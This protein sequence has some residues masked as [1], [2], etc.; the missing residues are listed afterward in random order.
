MAIEFKDVLD[1]T[2]VD[3]NT[4]N[5]VKRQG[6]L[7]ISD[8]DGLQAELDS[9]AADSDLTS[10]TGDISNP[11][12]VTKDQ[13]GLG[14]VPNLDTT[15]AVNNEHTHSNKGAIDKVIDTGSGSNFL[16]DDGTYKHTGGSGSST[17]TGLT[18][19]PGSYS[20]SAGKYVAVNGSA[21]ALEFTDA[22]PGGGATTFDD[23]TDTP[24]SKQADKFVK[25]SSDGTS[26]IYADGT[27]PVD[28]TGMPVTETVF[29]LASITDKSDGD[30]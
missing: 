16:A 20:G 10:H 23:L 5:A 14:S 21:N 6:G 17:F 25:V 28:I 13:V 4:T 7:E 3:S 29:T 24:S 2:E 15:D 12:S 8:T 27:A 9:K 30:V 19:T 11:H 22:P 1:S 26:L 18:D